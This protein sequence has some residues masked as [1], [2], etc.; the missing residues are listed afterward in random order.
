MARRS[1]GGQ[2][3]VEQATPPAITIPLPITPPAGRLV[4]L[5]PDWLPKA[6]IAGDFV[7]AA[8]QVLLA[9]WFHHR[10]DPIHTLTPGEL[11]LGP[12]LAAIP[13]VVLIY[14]AALTANHQYQSWRGRTL[15]DLLL[16]LYS[17]IG[18]AAI[19]ILAVISI[20]NLGSHYS[21]LTI[22]YA[23]V[24]SAVLMTV[25]RYFLRQYETR[26]RRQGIGTERVLMVGTGAGSEMLIQRMN[27]FP[28]Y[29]FQ[30]IGVMMLRP[31]RLPPITSA[32]IKVTSVEGPPI[33]RQGR[34]GMHRRGEVVCKFR[35]V[36]PDAEAARGPVVP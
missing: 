15:V 32:S 36:R 27:M 17:G 9:S 8:A 7:V 4:F 11:P 29:R 31:R 35:T 19:L 26:L 10:F 13:F 5:P 1:P 34:L 28:Q 22:T 33:V 24:L 6:L 12:Y 30:V 3:R 21:R 16:Q 20:T 2:A 25:E 14:V 18:L 23:I